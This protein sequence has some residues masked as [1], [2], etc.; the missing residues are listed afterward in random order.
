MIIATL[1]ISKAGTYSALWPCAKIAA[2]LPNV[3]MLLPLYPSCAAFANGTDPNAVAPVLANLGGKTAA[4]SGAALNLSFGMALWLATAIHAIGIEIYLHLTPKEANRLRQVSYQRQ[5]EAGMRNPG[6]AGLVVQKLGDA[7][8]WVPEEKLSGAI[9]S[10]G[11][12]R[13]EMASD[14]ADV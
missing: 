1:I 13:T 5:L 8:V 3:H 11:S 7:D 12:R 14:E 9:K 10:A 2:T 4:N 6:S